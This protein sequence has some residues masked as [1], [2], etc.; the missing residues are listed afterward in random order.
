MIIVDTE[1]NDIQQNQDARMI[2]WIW[3]NVEFYQIILK[4]CICVLG[5]TNRCKKW[6][7]LSRQSFSSKNAIDNSNIEFQG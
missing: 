7:Q 5:Y 4:K 6:K 3:S 2:I 1:L